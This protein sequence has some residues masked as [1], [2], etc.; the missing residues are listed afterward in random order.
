MN[1]SEAYQKAGKVKKQQAKEARASLLE[2]A[3]EFSESESCQHILKRIDEL[4]D[5]GLMDLYIGRNDSYYQD[6][7]TKYDLG[8]QK[9]ME[10]LG[11]T[12]KFTTHGI[13][14]VSWDLSK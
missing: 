13:L 12:A 9:Y 11:F 6:L 3:K 7:V 8:G 5:Q 10:S 2:K 14:H 4:S 1:A